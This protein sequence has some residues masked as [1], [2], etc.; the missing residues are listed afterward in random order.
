M[1]RKKAEEVKIETATEEENTVVPVL[2]TKKEEKESI[3]LKQVLIDT[4]IKEK[5]DKVK[6]AI[7]KV[8]EK[9]KTVDDLQQVLIDAAVEIVEITKENKFNTVGLTEQQI[10][11]FKIGL[12]I[13]RAIKGG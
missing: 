2:E 10:N 6:V 7:D 13:Y 8:K 12:D 3:D 5:E 11:T 9:E 1:A 4:A